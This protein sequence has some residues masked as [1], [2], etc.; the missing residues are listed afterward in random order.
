MPTLRIPFNT[1]QTRFAEILLKHGFSMEK[2]T[3]CARIFTEN[4]LDGVYTH[5]LDRFPTFISMIQE[6]LVDCE[7]A[8]ELEGTNGLIEQWN[9]NLGPGMLNAEFCMARAIALA[10]EHGIGCVAIRN[11]NHW[12]R[13]G[14]YGWQAANA[15]FIGICFTNMIANVPPW[16][17]IDP[18]LGNNPLVIAVPRPGGPVVLDMAISQFS[19]GKLMQYKSAGEELPVP[20]GYDENGDLSTNAS[21][22]ISTKRLLPIGFW[23]GSGLSLMLDLLVTILS[24]GQST[25]EISEKGKEHGISQV[26]I[27]IRQDDPELNARLI[28]QIL[29]YT[30]SSR[31]RDADKPVAYPGENTLLTRKRNLEGGI[32]VDEGIWDRVLGM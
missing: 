31:P 20:G 10:G 28:E 15:G 27:S 8:S 25:K 24:K 2:A 32:P 6:G 11:T 29:D 30:K 26:F 22:V 19:F 9:G 4:S 18:R 7:A 1:M 5:G 17:G 23:K 14:T 16:G 3:H 13:G 21:D 12:M